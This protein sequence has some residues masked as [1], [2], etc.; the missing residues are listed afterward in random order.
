MNKV[1]LI[2]AA[3]TKDG[4]NLSPEDEN[5]LINNCDI[6][7]H[8]A[9]CVQFDRG[10]HEICDTNVGG[11]KNL[12]ELSKSMKNLKAFVFCSTAFSQYTGILLEERGYDPPI[13][14]ANLRQILDKFDENLINPLTAK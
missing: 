10:I 3:F 11:L 14:L 1:I 13:E 12:L 9:A 8:N 7:F 6:V 4:L 2:N 5:T